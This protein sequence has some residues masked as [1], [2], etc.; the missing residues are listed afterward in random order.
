[1]QFARR[2][3]LAVLAH[4]RHVYTDYDSRLRS[5]KQHRNLARLNIERQCVSKLLKWRG[6]DDEFELEER[7]AEVLIIDDSDEESDNDLTKFDSSSSDSD[8]EIM[9]FYDSETKRAHFI[10]KLPDVFNS[11]KYAGLFP[12]AHDP[13]QAIEA[14][15]PQTALFGYPLLS[16]APSIPSWG[17][18]P[19]RAQSHHAQSQHRASV[20][21]GFL[22][23][24][25]TVPQSPFAVPT[26][27][28]P[29]TPI[30]G[31]PSI[32]RCVFFGYP[33]VSANSC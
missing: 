2:V 19:A 3:Q 20:V 22:S 11:P 4:I 26:T 6:E 23:G 28:L 8:V 25:Y 30:F 21:P 29:E 32:P 16:R 31:N 7:E 17:A 1:L 15:R 14:R 27:V 13:T 18:P 33:V 10:S 12:K 5:K 24:G 9:G